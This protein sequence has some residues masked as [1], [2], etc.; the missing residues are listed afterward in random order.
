MVK[1]K[2][3]PAEKDVEYENEDSDEDFKDSEGDY[4]KSDD[5]DSDESYLPTSELDGVD[6]PEWEEFKKLRLLQQMKMERENLNKA[7]S[8]DDL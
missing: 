3:K 6:R 2:V 8:K 5:D 1:E 4:F 7:L